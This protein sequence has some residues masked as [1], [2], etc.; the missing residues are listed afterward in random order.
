MEAGARL[1]TLAVRLEN[2]PDQFTPPN[3]LATVPSFLVVLMI[4]LDAGFGKKV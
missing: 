4:P 2:V 3:S 1:A